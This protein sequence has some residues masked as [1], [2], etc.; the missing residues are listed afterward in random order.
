[1]Q[2]QYNKQAYI[3]YAFVCTG[4]FIFYNITIA[5]ENKLAEINIYSFRRGVYTTMKIP[6]FLHHTT[7]KI[8]ALGCFDERVLLL[9][10][11]TQSVTASKNK[12]ATCMDSS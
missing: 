8:P 6:V 11:A 3:P 9:F 2:K 4:N 10:T 1:M 5:L 7:V 12:Q